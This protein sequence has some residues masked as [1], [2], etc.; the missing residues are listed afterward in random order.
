MPLP[1]PLG[2]PC[3]A[4]RE[5]CDGHRDGKQP[6]GVCWGWAVP[7]CPR[8]SVGR[9]E[10][11]S[12]CSRW[13]NG[14]IANTRRNGQQRKSLSRKSREGSNKA[15][16]EWPPAP[17]HWSPGVRGP[18]CN[19]CRHIP[20]PCGLGPHPTFSPLPPKEAQPQ[21]YFSPSRPEQ[22]VCIL[23]GN[24]AGEQGCPPRPQAPSCQRACQGASGIQLAKV[25]KG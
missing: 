20:S 2:P 12:T 13:V 21:V 18:V 15:K 11:L 7:K 19:V 25:V 4:W 5:G 3:M 6:W 9:E 16:P 10:L 22:R 24:I 14:S 8:V 17:E 23:Q 1:V